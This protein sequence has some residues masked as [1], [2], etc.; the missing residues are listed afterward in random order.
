MDQF[1]TKKDSSNNVLLS[2][3]IPLYNEEK[4]LMSGFEIIYSF[5][6]DKPYA[7]EII[8]VDDG[9]ADKTRNM[10][11]DIANRYPGVR[12]VKNKKN[13]GKGAA[14]KNGVLSA[15][16]DIVLFTDIDFSVPA[17]YI[18]AF[19]E[20]IKEGYDFAVGSRRIKGS[21][22]DVHQPFLREFMGRGFT[23]L[24]N[25]ILGVNFKDH[26]CGMK[27]FK[28]EAARALFSRQILERWAFDSEI[29]YLARKMNYRIIEVP[30]L[31]RDM[32][33]T[34]VSKFKDAITS[35]MEIVKARFYHR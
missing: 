9:S 22:I 24:S 19:V 20:K 26:T 25:I 30:V 5:F 10:I 11:Y 27:A 28:K 12:S 6:K 14:V 7:W 32:P 33:G 3:V 23:F 16:G 2:V 17:S 1:I 29:L 18:D 31:W 21:I 8:F 4:R 35:L 15:A 34:K 13:L